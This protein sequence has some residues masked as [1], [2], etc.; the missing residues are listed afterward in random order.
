MIGAS[1]VLVALPKTAAYP[2]AAQVIAGSP[3]IPLKTTPS[4]APMEKSG[5]TSPPW[6]PIAS[7]TIVNTSFKI[8]S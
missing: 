4:V 6:N 2:S 5:V 1:S 3:K 7:V 8:Q